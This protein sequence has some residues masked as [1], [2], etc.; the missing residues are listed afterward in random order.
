MYLNLGKKAAGEF[1]VESYTENT[2]NKNFK[3]AHECEFSDT[4]ILSGLNFPP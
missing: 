2:K 1:R 4:Q 3:F